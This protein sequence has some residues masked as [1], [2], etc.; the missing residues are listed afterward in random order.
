MKKKKNSKEGEH[1]HPNNQETHPFHQYSPQ[2]ATFLAGN[3]AYTR[4]KHSSQRVMLLTR[5]NYHGNS[6]TT[7]VGCFNRFLGLTSHVFVMGPN[8]KRKKEATR[9]QEKIS[10]RFISWHKTILTCAFASPAPGLLPLTHA[11]SL[12]AAP[13]DRTSLATSQLSKIRSKRYRMIQHYPCQ[14]GLIRSSRRESSAMRQPP[15]IR[16]PSGRA[17]QPHPSLVPRAGGPRGAEPADGS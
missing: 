11:W 12:Y 6:Y 1:S 7:L 5:G 17:A 8:Q 2:T 14:S 16:L 3:R 10:S 4:P 15:G 9:F 13:A